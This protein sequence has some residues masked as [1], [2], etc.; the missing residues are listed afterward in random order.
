MPGGPATSPLQSQVAP[1]S[2]ERGPGP[3]HRPPLPKPVREARQLWALHMP[4]GTR[5]PSPGT[6]AHSDGWGAEG[7][8][9]R[10]H[11]VSDG[12]AAHR[13]AASQGPVLSTEAPATWGK[14]KDHSSQ[15]FHRV[16]GG[17]LCPRT[18]GSRCCLLCT[19]TGWVHLG[20]TFGLKPRQLLPP[21]NKAASPAQGRSVQWLPHHSSLHFGRLCLT[22]GHR[23]GTMCW[24]EVW[25]GSADGRLALCH[26][27]SRAGVALLGRR[28]PSRYACEQVGV[29]TTEGSQACAC[30]CSFTC[31]V[32][33]C[34]GLCA[35]ACQGMRKRGLSAL[36]CA[37]APALCVHVC[38]WV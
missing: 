23:P 6:A 30:T 37:R 5:S 29:G 17:S 25:G 3:L 35:P 9:G 26:P 38:G 27:R 20:S 34:T 31:T 33:T 1:E 11:W 13:P 32:S 22:D 2:T 24:G 14:P 19:G 28:P 15:S 10:Q 7:W 21:G 12:P 4:T 8:A 16:A 36:A 18:P